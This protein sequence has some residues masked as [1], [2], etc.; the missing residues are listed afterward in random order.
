MEQRLKPAAPEIDTALVMINIQQRVGFGDGLIHSPEQSIDEI[1]EFAEQLVRRYLKKVY[2]DA[3]G[4]CI[5]GRYCVRTI[6]GTP[7]RLGPRCVGGA[8]QSAFG[9]AELTPDYYGGL[10]SKDV[11]ERASEIGKL[12]SARGIAIG[13]HTTEIA[14]SNGYINPKNNKVQTGCGAAEIHPDALRRIASLDEN[15]LKTTAVLVN[16]DKVNT[17]NVISEEVAKARTQNYSPRK[18]F[19]IVESQNRGRSAEVLRGEHEERAVV[20][21]WVRGTTI[22][23]DTLFEETG[24]EVFVIDMWYLSDIADAL[25]E[26]RPDAD[27]MRETIYHNL[28]AYQLGVYAALCDGSQPVIML[29]HNRA[30]AT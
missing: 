30:L 8:L 26:G 22:D 5:D 27:T 28:V 29:K 6:A 21:N 7:T 9:A 4:Q 14:R 18:M 17:N 11:T 23:R 2:S 3:P 13:G 20:F 15:V 12:L 1:T 24:Q 16:V 19:S 10:S 25:T